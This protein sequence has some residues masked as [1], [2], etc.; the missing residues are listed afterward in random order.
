M[1][2]SFEVSA[3]RVRELYGHS[4][5]VVSDGMPAIDGNDAT[6][7]LPPE[8]AVVELLHGEPAHPRF[9]VPGFN[10]LVGVDPQDAYRQLVEQAAT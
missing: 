3:D 2:S 5:V 10:I 8:V 9:R 6:P 4:R 1:A 7:F